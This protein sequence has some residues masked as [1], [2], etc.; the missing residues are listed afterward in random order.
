MAHEA[1]RGRPDGNGNGNGYSG[2]AG[3]QNAGEQIRDI[4]HVLFKRKRL[5][6]ALFLAVALPS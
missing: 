1:H 4:V 2:S 3:P 6:A 5:I